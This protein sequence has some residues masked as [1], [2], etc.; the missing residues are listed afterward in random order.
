M[1]DLEKDTSE[2]SIIDR[3]RLIRTKIKEVIP[4]DLTE[5][6]FFKDEFQNH[7]Y[8]IVQTCKCMEYVLESREAFQK[9]IAKL[10]S[11]VKPGGFLQLLT[12]IGGSW[13]TCSNVCSLY[14]L[15]V[16]EDDVLEGCRMAGTY[17]YACVNM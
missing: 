8:D 9:A 5:P 4:C 7:Q 16:T 11:Y 10:A 6:P 17:A 12:C 3:E 15:N 2:D 13:Y 1:K 14:G